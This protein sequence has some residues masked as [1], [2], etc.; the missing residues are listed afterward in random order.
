MIGQLGI[1]GIVFNVVFFAAVIALVVLAIWA[2]ILSIK[3]LQ[4]YLGQ[5]NATGSVDQNS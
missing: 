2:L 5:S 3:A 4:K 1:V